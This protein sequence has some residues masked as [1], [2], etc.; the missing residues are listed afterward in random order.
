MG[1]HRKYY[2][3]GKVGIDMPHCKAPL[4][5]EER[6]LATREYDDP[7]KKFVKRYS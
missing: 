4:F 6:K 3:D 5:P 7:V 1:E 2:K